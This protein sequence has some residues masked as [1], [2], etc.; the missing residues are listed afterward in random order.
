MMPHLPSISGSTSWHH[1]NFG[2]QCNGARPPAGSVPTAQ[3]DNLFLISLNMN[4]FE[5]KFR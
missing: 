4:D 2:F 5:K 1:D 3:T